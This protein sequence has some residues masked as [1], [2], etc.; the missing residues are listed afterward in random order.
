MVNR[1]GLGKILK[2]YKKWT[3]STNL[4]R[5]FKKN[6]LD[7][8]TSY[9]NQ[10]FLLSLARYSRI[11]AD[12]R[13]AGSPVVGS[14]QHVAS[15]SEAG[16]PVSTRA[17]DLKNV[18]ERGSKSEIDTAIA[19]LPLGDPAETTC[20]WIH[21][22]NLLQLQVLLLRHAKSRKDQIPASTPSQRSSLH[23]RKGSTSESGP[24][25]PIQSGNEACTIVCDDLSTFARRRNSAPISDSEDTA[26]RSLEDS[27]ASIQLS[28]TTDAVVVVGAHHKA[29]FDNGDNQGQPSFQTTKVKR[30]ALRRLFDAKA[31]TEDITSLAELDGRPQESQSSES[32]DK[33]PLACTCL[34][35]TTK[36]G[37]IKQWLSEHPKVQPLLELRFH[38][39]RFAGTHNTAKTGL[40]ATLDTEVTMAKSTLLSLGKYDSSESSDDTD[41]AIHQFPYAILRVRVE[42]ES[43]SS[44]IK[45][46]DGSHLVNILQIK[47]N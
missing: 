24:I 1:Q 30:K 26:G 33:S 5:R 41:A 11:L 6:V 27:A 7:R 16:K 20:Y 17:A 25:F 47:K 13:L 23:S 12:I 8:A 32:V 19:V 45:E 39:C 9:T 38:R 31:T 21:P 2:K 14:V 37:A 44:L 34:N 3:D 4:E 46:L 35:V 10:D 15:T 28:S 22:E 40:W 36:P 43:S 42:G 18:Y 29:K